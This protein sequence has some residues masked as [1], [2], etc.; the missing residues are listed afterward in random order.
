MALAEE[1]NSTSRE[2]LTAIVAGYEVMCRTRLALNPN[3]VRARGLHVTITGITGGST[4]G[5][6]LRLA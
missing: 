6:Q 4:R 3:S 2:L 5:E 1:M